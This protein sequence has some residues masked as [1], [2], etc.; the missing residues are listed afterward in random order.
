MVFGKYPIINRI[1]ST[2]AYNRFSYVW[3]NPLKFVDPNG[4]D[5]IPTS[6]LPDG[7]GRTSR[8]TGW[9]YTKAGETKD[10]ISSRDPSGGF[11]NWLKG[12]FGSSGAPSYINESSGYSAPRFLASTGFGLPQPDIN[13]NTLSGTSSQNPWDYAV[14]MGPP[15][16]AEPSSATTKVLPFALTSAAADG[17]VPI[18]DALGAIVLAGASVYD[19]TQR[20][21]ITYTLTNPTTGQIYAG[22]ASGFGD[23]YRIMMNRYYGHHMR[24]LGFVNPTL[25]RAVQGVFAK[26]AIRGRE[27]Q[28]ID[29]HGGVGNRKVGNSIRAV[30]YFNPLGRGFHKYSNFFFGPLAP[31]TGF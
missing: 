29:L 8:A 30:S 18:G 21:Y 6:Y 1:Y 11:R 13:W 9:R 10:K 2:Q 5:G 4:Y 7:P 3:N 19:L 17:P 14:V 20:V 23:P 16:E 26:P 27:Q 15:G 31:Y 22:R 12:V 28:L 24:Q 25:D